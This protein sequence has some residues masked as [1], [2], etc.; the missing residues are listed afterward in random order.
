MAKTERAFVI[1]TQEWFDLAMRPLVTGT[2]S[3][4]TMGIHLIS[5]IVED[6]ADHR[7]LWLRDIRTSQP[8]EDGATVTM[9]L[10]IPWQFVVSVGVVEEDSAKLQ[11]GFAID[12]T[13]EPVET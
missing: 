9:R 12:L 11:P 10:M 4:S 5:A 3:R 7:G 8:T 1:V 13:A 2:K 6:L